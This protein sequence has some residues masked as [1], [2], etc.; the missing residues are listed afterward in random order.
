MQVRPAVHQD[1]DLRVI[2]KGVAEVFAEVVLASGHEDD[3]STTA[4]PLFTRHRTL[5]CSARLLT[6]RPPLPGPKA[7]VIHLLEY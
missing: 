1:L 3:P 4:P 6:H 5:T 2:S 7:L